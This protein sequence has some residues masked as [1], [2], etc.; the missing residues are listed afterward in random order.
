MTSA[1]HLLTEDRPE[2]ERI[3]DEALRTAP[4]RPELAAMGERLTAEQLR[5]MALGASALLT[6]AAAA[7]YDH[8]VKVREERRYSALYPHK[9]SDT[10][11]S[12]RRSAAAPAPSA[13]TPSRSGTRPAATNH[14]AWAGLGRRFGVAVLGAGQPGGR[15]ISDGVA[16]PRWAR[17]SYSRR[18]LAALLGL[19]VRPAVPSAA[20]GRS[21]RTPEPPPAAAR[22]RPTSSE[23]PALET[24]E[25]A[26]AGLFTVVAVLA[27]VL[28]GTA[29]ALF[30]L[31]G[32]VLEMFSAESGSGRTMFAAGW[33]FVAVAVG[34]IAVCVVGL[35][36]TALRSSRDQ[37]APEAARDHEPSEEQVARA[38]EAWRNALLERGIMPFL[39]DALADPAPPRS[40]ASS[41]APGRIPDLGYTRPDF[42]SPSSSPNPAPGPRP[43]YTSP[44]FAGPERKPE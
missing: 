34:A 39:R 25:A 13:P 42:T 31:I 24:T 10:V 23:T 28:S 20:G 26:G 19:R 17:M 40:D 9:S 33:L 16:A 8:Y 36:V 30:F 43:S 37:P 6:A 4:D 32:L 5:T 35:L 38:R 41:R 29:A 7:E 3:L 27:P 1:P 44:D 15:R 12:S 22:T 11:Y 21:P 18:L 14:R 2:Y